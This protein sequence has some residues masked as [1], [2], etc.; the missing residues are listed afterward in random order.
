[1]IHHG[2]DAGFSSIT[3]TE[4]SEA[5]ADLRGAPH[6]DQRSSSECECGPEAANAGHLRT[7]ATPVRTRKPQS[8]DNG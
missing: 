1:M 4:R 8:V 2:N 3:A 5:G 7:L 6:D